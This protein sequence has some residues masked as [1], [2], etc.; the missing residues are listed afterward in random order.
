MVE[1]SAEAKARAMVEVQSF[2]FPPYIWR[3]IWEET[4]PKELVETKKKGGKWQ[5]IYEEKFEI[6]TGRYGLIRLMALW[7]ILTEIYLGNYP[8]EPSIVSMITHRVGD[9]STA[10]RVLSTILPSALERTREKRRNDFE[11]EVRKCIDDD[12]KGEELNKLLQDFR[13]RTRGLK[14]RKGEEEETK[15]EKAKRKLKEMVAKDF[16]D[17]IA[18]KLNEL[19]LATVKGILEEDFGWF[20]LRTE[21]ELNGTGNKDDKDLNDQIG[22]IRWTNEDVLKNIFAMV[23]TAIEVG[24]KARGEHFFSEFEREITEVYSKKMKVSDEH[25][26]IHLLLNSPTKEFS[27]TTKL[28]KEVQTCLE[29]YKYGF[30]GEE[31]KF[32]EQKTEFERLHKAINESKDRI[33][34]SPK[35]RWSDIIE[36]SPEIQSSDIAWWDGKFSSKN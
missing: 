12:N 20:E 11:C 15:E 35:I 21:L 34:K 19:S 36:N 33:K 7:Y 27:L 30:G 29:K 5:T 4:V 6:T 14:L 10:K 1:S 25:E 2:Y 31:M 28:G 22:C 18:A 16:G 8:T 17:D 13:E 26:Q 24:E 3:T 23:K 9:Q 32:S